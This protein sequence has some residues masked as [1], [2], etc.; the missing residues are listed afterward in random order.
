M[1]CAERKG[2]IWVMKVKH[3]TAA[4]SMA[5]NAL[6][7]LAFSV[8][9]PVFFKGSDEL[10]YRCVPEQAVHNDTATTG[11]LI[12]STVSDARGSS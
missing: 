4:I 6:A 2:I 8:N 5:V 9:K 12:S 1:K 7:A 3:D 10:S 11:S